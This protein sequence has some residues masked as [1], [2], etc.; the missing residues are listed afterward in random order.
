MRKIKNN[1]ATDV[2][3]KITK[4]EYEELL[5]IK[6]EYTKIKGLKND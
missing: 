5:S 4:K 6:E 3:E 2:N 1:L